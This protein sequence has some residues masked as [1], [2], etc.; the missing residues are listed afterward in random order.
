MEEWKELL[1]AVTPFGLDDD[2]VKAADSWRAFTKYEF[3]NTPKSVSD[4]RYRYQG[5]Y[6]ALETFAQIH[7]ES[8]EH[9]LRR[10]NNVR[11]RFPSN[12]IAPIHGKFFEEMKETRRKL[13]ETLPNTP[14]KQDYAD[15]D[16]QHIINFASR[17][18]AIVQNKSDTL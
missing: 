14:T 2:V 7:P 6:R 5:F 16:T 9:A 8:R 18:H 13:K 12:S 1:D 15:A 3:S 10:L 17:L 4:A 11:L